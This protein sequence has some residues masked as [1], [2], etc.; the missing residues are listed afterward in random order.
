MPTQARGQSLRSAR[1]SAIR[2]HHPD[3]GGSADALTAA[4]AAAGRDAA[5]PTVA[6]ATWHGRIGRFRAVL[7]GRLRRRRLITLADNRIR[8]DDIDSGGRS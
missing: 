3:A 7:V 6:I 4:L 5:S 1:R 8:H 2:R